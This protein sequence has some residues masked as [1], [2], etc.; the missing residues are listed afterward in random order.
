M[1][2]QHTLM[3]ASDYPHWDFDDPDEIN[4]PPAWRE[5][6]FDTNAREFYTCLPQREEPVVAVNG[7]A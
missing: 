7:S 5:R 6:V 4:I 3:F 2:S 1:D